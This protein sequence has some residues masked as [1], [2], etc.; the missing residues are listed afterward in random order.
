M[1]RITV[2]VK[3][4]RFVK[5][6]LLTNDEYNSY[7]QIYSVDPKF[8]ITPK[9]SFWEEFIEIK[10]IT[11]AVAIGLPLSLIWEPFAI[12][13]GVPLLILII[14]LFTGLGQSIINFFL[15]VNKKNRYY[16]KMKKT[17]IMSDDYIQFSNSM[18]RVNSRFR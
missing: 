6:D 2:I 3:K 13:Y 8:K 4:Y 11:I 15:L 1:A 10:W 5:P 9:Y 17:I 12:I 16:K 7:R 14:G 18:R